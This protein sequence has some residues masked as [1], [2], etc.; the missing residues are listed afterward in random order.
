MLKGFRKWLSKIGEVLVSFWKLPRINNSNGRGVVQVS[1][2]NLPRINHPNG[3]LLQ[4]SFWN[5]QDQQPERGGA[6]IFLE[7]PRINN[8]N[9]GGCA[10]LFLEV[11]TF[12]TPSGGGLCK[13]LS[14]IAKDQE[15]KELCRA[16]MMYFLELYFW[17]QYLDNQSRLCEK[18][19]VHVEH[20]WKEACFPL[21]WKE[22]IYRVLGL[23]WMV[24]E[25][26]FRRAHPH[27]CKS[28]VPI[29]HSVERRK[30]L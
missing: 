7:L 11:P 18:L 3:G 15:R 20:H 23:A 13:S 10:S 29:S 28:Y 24:R 19:R 9:G 2:W 4:I 30:N 1:F 22:A 26:D 6:S 8:P 27:P 25:L 16:F 14:R 17:N 12:N 21:F 5:C